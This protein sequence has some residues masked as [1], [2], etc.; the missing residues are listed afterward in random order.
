[1]NESQKEMLEAFD[2]YMDVMTDDINIHGKLN[3]ASQTITFEIDEIEF[4]IDLEW[5]TL[6]IETRNY[7]VDIQLGD[8]PEWQCPNSEDA[9]DGAMRIQVYKDGNG[10]GQTDTPFFEINHT[11]PLF[12]EQDLQDKREANHAD[13]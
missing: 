1:M 6:I 8:T 9:I 10:L 3:K 7:G 4:S 5:K 2:R 13:D 12:S 11:L